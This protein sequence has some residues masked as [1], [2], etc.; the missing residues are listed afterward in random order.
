MNKPEF[1][2]PFAMDKIGHSPVVQAIT[3]SESECAALAER[4]KISAIGLLSAGYAV[5]K[6]AGHAGFAVEGSLRAVVRQVCVVTGE[7]FDS[8]VEVPVRTLF[9]RAQSSAEAAEQAWD[10]IE[11]VE[12]GLMDLGELTSQH[13]SLSLDPY[14]RSRGGHW[15]REWNGCPLAG[16]GGARRWAGR[17]GDHDAVQL[18]RH[19]QLDSACGGYA[20]AGRCGRAHLQSFA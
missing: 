11:I 12:D 19:R 5:A 13:L 7:L 8:D 15:L 1:S 2:R 18:F 10:D 9:V 17:C 6:A 3:A 4:L 16:A 20:A 14:P